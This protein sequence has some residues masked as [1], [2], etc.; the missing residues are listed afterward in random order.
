MGVLESFSLEGKNAV[1]I[2]GSKGLGK[3]IAKGLAEAGAAVTVSSRNGADCEKA[4]LQI[5]QETGRDAFG[6]PID[7]TDGKNVVEVIHT[8]IDCMG[9]IDILVNSAGINIRKPSV[10]YTE[11]DWDKV[12][13]VQLRGVFLTCRA[14]AEHMIERGIPGKIINISS[15]NAKVVARPNIVSYVAAKAGVMQMTKAL[16]CEWAQYG[17]NVNAIA[18]G[19][20]KTELTKAVFENPELQ[21]EMMAHIPMK[22]FGNPDKDLAGMAVYLASSASDYMTGQLVCIDGGYTTI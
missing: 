3:G 6:V 12:Q 8:I 17:I 19:W 5:A 11:A 14:V 1:V 13:A 21:K 18:P 9:Q 7:V 15:V 22:R 2:G 4:A 10:E 16:A 20:F